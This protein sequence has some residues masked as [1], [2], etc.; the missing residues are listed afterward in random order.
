MVA[1]LQTASESP[2]TLRCKGGAKPTVAAAGPAYLARAQEAAPSS[3]SRAHH[4]KQGGHNTTIKIV[5]YETATPRV[6]ELAPEDESH[7]SDREGG[8]YITVWVPDQMGSERCD[9]AKGRVGMPFV[10]RV[11]VAEQGSCYQDVVGVES[12]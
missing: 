12:L 5:Q 3:R 10:R 9:E 4:A 1:A 11:R 8:R 6:T 2:E 7:C